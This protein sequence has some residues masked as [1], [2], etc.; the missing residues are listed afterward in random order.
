MKIDIDIDRENLVLFLILF[1]T[2]ILSQIE[3]HC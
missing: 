3:K 2:C 1:L